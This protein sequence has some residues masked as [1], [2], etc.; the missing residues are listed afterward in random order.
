M[1]KLSKVNKALEALNITEIPESKCQNKEYVNQ[2]ILEIGAGSA[3]HFNFMKCSYNEYHI[4]ETSDYAEDFHKNNPKVKKLLAKQA[5][6]MPSTKG[7]ILSFEKRLV[8][9]A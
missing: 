8:D 4:A 1:Y 6:V 5:T 3:P 7:V 9:A 2:K